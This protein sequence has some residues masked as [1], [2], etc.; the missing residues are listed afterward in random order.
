MLMG[1][2]LL[3][4]VRLRPVTSLRR[5]VRR[6]VRQL[7]KDA[8]WW[9]LGLLAAL[10]GIAEEVAFRGVLQ[11]LAIGTLGA[12][13]GIVAASL[14]FGLVH[15]ADRV[16]FALATALGAYLGVLAYSTGEIVSAI[17]AHALY[18]LVAFVWLLRPRRPSG[19]RTPR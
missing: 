3:M 17:V 14:A 12:G 13:V 4:R 10:A 16:Y 11:P 15:A 1:L 5:R 6:V 19:D 18:D 9:E 7:L 2:A 8:R